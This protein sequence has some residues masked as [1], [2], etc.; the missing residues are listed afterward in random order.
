M[1]QLKLRF[2]AV[3]SGACSA[4]RG[5][6]QKRRTV[7]V[8]KAGLPRSERT[9]R[10]VIASM[11]PNL[12]DLNILRCFLLLLFALHCHHRVGPRQQPSP[13]HAHT[14]K[15]PPSIMGSMPE[16][17][18]VT[19]VLVVG[20]AYG[21]LSVAL[22]LQDLCRGL[23]PRCGEKPTDDEQVVVAQ[24]ALDITIV[25]ERDGYC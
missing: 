18:N 3:A 4:T 22:N 14:P 5:T 20:G 2:G 24:F 21:G 15:Q 7:L 13:S 10:T 1:G 25:D 12:P 16:P 11:I 19:R 6:P 8:D 17:V 23:S 9:N